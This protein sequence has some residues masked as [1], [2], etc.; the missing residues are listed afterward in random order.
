MSIRRV[1]TIGFLVGVCALALQLTHGTRVSAAGYITVTPASGGQY[2]YYEFDATGYVPGERIHIYF[3]SPDGDEFDW[4]NSYDGTDGVIV[5]RYGQFSITIHPVDD[6]SGSQF[7]V[8]E[9]HFDS[10]RGTE[11]LVDFD[12]E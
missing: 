6:F 10:D 1:L 7:G 4:V 12:V 2:N 5:D 9:G 3:I 8:W 11:T